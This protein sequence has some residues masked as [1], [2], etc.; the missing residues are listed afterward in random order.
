MIYRI[1]LVTL[2]IAFT[3]AMVIAQDFTDEYGKVT[4]YEIQMKEYPSDKEAE[5]LVIFDKAKSYFEQSKDHFDVVFERITRIKIFS[6]RGINWAEVEIPFYQEKNIYEEVYDIEAISYNIDNENLSRTRLDLD[7]VYTQKKDDSWNLKKFAVPDVR[8][9]SVIE[10]RYKIRSQYLFNFR[11]WEFQWRI[12]VIYSEYEVRMI[13]F[14]EY[15][16]ILQG[17]SN[18]DIYK[19][20]EDKE[21]SRYFGTSGAYRENIYNDMVYKF[22]MKNIPAFR[23]EEFISSVHDYIIKLDFQLSKVYSLDGT[24]Q[25]I[26]T[27]W[28]K[29]ISELL[30]HQDFG[31]YI[32]KSKGYTNK[33][34]DFEQIARMPEME[35]FNAVMDYVKSNYNWNKQKTKFATKSVR[36]FIEDKY[37]SSADINLFTVGL[38]NGVGIESHPVIIS[39]RDHGKPKL[40]YPFSHFFNYVIVSANIGYRTILSD[41]TEILSNNDRIPLR[42]LN[43]KGLIIKEDSIGWIDLEC[44]FTSEEVNILHIKVEENELSIDLSM[45]ATEYDALGFRKEY[46][47]KQD[48]INEL[49]AKNNYSV[50]DSTII[51]G[52]QYDKTKPYELSYSLKTKTEVVNDKIFILPFLQESMSDNP[53]KQKERKY[54]VDLIYPRKVSYKSTICL[55]DKYII[56]FIPEELKINNELFELNY[57][58]SK[59][60]NEVIVLFD[61][62]FKRAVYQSSEYRKIKYYFN[63]VVRKGNEK[64][65]L[66]RKNE[67]SN[68]D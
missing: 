37:G 4:E 1:R 11:D 64:I 10:Y 55:N 29:L 20:Y 59:N 67:N 2:L 8:K 6:E 36:N 38:L 46:S 68:Y 65:V 5:A 48:I 39:T 18:F 66:T 25:E 53:L 61:Y 26:L 40:N 28:E 50:I 41:A 47:D 30:K 52:N 49:I 23:D 54:P 21:T 3:N 27:T 19:S 45:I 24:S 32:D 44:Q 57:S 17:T 22:G 35:R 7:N 15:T 63:E 43:D 42:C 34:P 9:G 13:P 58:L 31:R 51:I 62:H 60:R 12:P 56:D 14:Y 16:F 33:L